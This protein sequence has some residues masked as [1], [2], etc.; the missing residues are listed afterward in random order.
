MLGLRTQPGEY[1]VI[2]HQ[3]VDAGSAGNADNVEQWTVA[4]RGVRQQAQA[5]LRL[6]RLQRLP[7]QQHFGIGQLGEDLER[8]RQ[9]E[10]RHARKQQQSDSDG[11]HGG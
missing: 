8:S 11:G 6:D 4:Q 9:V 10:L 7:Q 5:G 1:F 3:R 2:L